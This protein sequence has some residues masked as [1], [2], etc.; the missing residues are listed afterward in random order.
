LQV[1]EK[2]LFTVEGS[3][4]SEASGV[5]SMSHGRDAIKFNIIDHR[6]TTTLRTEQF[7]ERSPRFARP[8]YLT[9]SHA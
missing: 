9:Y 5:V 6:A 4:S 1:A 3:A 2:I 8:N 7:D